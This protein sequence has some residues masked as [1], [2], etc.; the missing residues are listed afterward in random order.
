MPIHT[1]LQHT[2][3]Q[4]MT[5]ASGFHLEAQIN[6][7]SRPE[8]YIVPIIFHRYKADKHHDNRYDVADI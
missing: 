1:V 4:T 6:P 3:K 8:R 2:N 7:F 5:P